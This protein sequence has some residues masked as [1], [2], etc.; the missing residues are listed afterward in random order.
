MIC[1]SPFY[2]VDHQIS[3]PC[4][5]CA[6]CRSA[7]AHEWAV[8]MQHEIAT[9]SC[10]SFG[11][12]TFN[13]ANYP[14]DGS[15]RISDL[16]LFFKRL[17]KVLDGRRIRYFA[18]GEYGSRFGRAHYH[19]VLFNVDY[20]LDRAAVDRAWNRGFTELS[21]VTFARC[22]YV[23][24]YM[25]KFVMGTRPKGAA[26]P[27]TTMSNGIGR[28]WCE[29]NAVRLWSNLCVRSQGRTIPIPKYY[30]KVLGIPTYLLSE[31]SE[32]VLEAEND[33]LIRKVGLD[34][35]KGYERV[36]SERKQ[37]DLELRAGAKLRNKGVM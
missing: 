3:V 20:E 30:V 33:R 37:R 25:D 35:E 15:V 19:A 2:I 11:S 32:E 27:F 17:R 9:S 4:G 36:L 23:A 22:R 24:N 5:R 28:A 26:A 1:T 12:F 6:A 14:K 10:A 16:Q 13:P 29:E 34:I 31:D 21:E 18:C 7:R 8:R